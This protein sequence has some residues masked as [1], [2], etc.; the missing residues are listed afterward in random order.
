[1]I[2]SFYNGVAGIKAHQNAVDLLAENVSNV[3]TPGYRAST[4]LFSTI[5][6]NELNSTD[7][8]NDPTSNEI[9]YGSIFSGSSY[10][11]K[12]GSLIDSDNKYDLAIQGSGFFGVQNPNGEVSYTRN[13]GFSKDSDGMLVDGNGNHLLGISAFNVEHGRI[14]N[15]P[16]H[17]IKAQKIGNE[18]PIQIPESLFY[19]SIPTTFVKFSG[20]LNPT[21]KEK[22][23]LDGTK[24]QVP[25]VE[26]FQTEV[27]D[28]KGNNN[29][30]E[31][32]FTKRV[33]QIGTSTTWDA[34]AKI[35]DKNGDLIS[36]NEGVLEF[37]GYGALI[38]NTL[39][40]IDNNGS[41]IKL[42][43]GTTYQEGIPNSGYDGLKSILNADGRS[44]KKDGAK[45]GILED[46]TIDDNGV[47]LASF[48]NGKT[49]PIAKIALYHFVNEEGLE[50]VGNSNFKESVNSGKAKFFVDSKG[51]FSKE[52]KILS[53]KTELSNVDLT[54]ALT[55]LIAMQKAFDANS[56]S[57]TTS[58]QL[59]QNAINMKK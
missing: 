39:T 31:L 1:M 40:N 50:K 36:K 54:T 43:L 49:L 23:T 12:S 25:N 41:P 56:K 59:I 28:A 29:R 21:I 57:I 55:E 3:N 18:K 42:N 4:P 7:F 5:F 24:V 38:S 19:P 37:N 35:L 46:Y 33:P 2:T 16:N 8:V 10:N 58:D 22:L 30:L 17:T 9:G 6:S 52:S 34:E 14:I 27:Q 47:L 45:E 15:N 11:T 13:G 48:N 20:S 32:K 53:S 26:I 51:N 44:I